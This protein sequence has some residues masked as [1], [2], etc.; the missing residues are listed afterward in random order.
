MSDIAIR[1]EGLSEWYKI[2]QRERYNALRDVLT[3]AFT[4]PFRR[5]GLSFQRSNVQTCQRSTSLHEQVNVGNNVPLHNRLHIPQ[6]A[7][8]RSQFEIQGR[9]V[10]PILRVTVSPFPRVSPSR[11]SALGAPFPRFTDSPFPP[12]PLSLCPSE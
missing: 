3:D 10:S 12:V 9:S 6:F 7:I 8:R 2:G 11:H 5:L 1:V 4:S